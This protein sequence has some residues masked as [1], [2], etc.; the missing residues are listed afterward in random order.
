MQ[1][2]R[3]DVLFSPH[4]IRR[5]AALALSFPCNAGSGAEPTSPALAQSAKGL[6]GNGMHRCNTTPAALFRK[7]HCGY[8]C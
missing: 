1:Q 6:G 5:A 4:G 3:P 2:R 7:R 8:P